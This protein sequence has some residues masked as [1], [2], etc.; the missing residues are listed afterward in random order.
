MT[1]CYNEEGNVIAVYERVKAVFSGINQYSYEHVFVDNASTDKTVDILEKIAEKD[2]NVKIIVNTRNFGPAHSSY[3]G[4]L[5]SKADATILLVA[6]LQDPP[7]LIKDSLASWEQG[8]KIVAGVKINSKESRIMFFLRKLY[9]HFITKISEVSLIKNFF[10]FGLYDREVI[11][12]LKALNEPEPYLRGLISSI[13]Y[14]IKEIGYTQEKRE[15]GFSKHSFYVLYDIAMSGITSHSKL[16]LRIATLLGFSCSFLSF[17]VAVIFFIVKL[18]WWSQFSLGLA[19]LIIGLFALGSVQLFCIGIL[20][21]YIA[22]INSR[23]MNRPLVIE[24]ERIN[25]DENSIFN[26]TIQKN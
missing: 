23:V 4:L 24:K 16:P 22:L 17:I 15:R 12:I 6:D 11:N 9:Y 25:F 2:K 20:G 13:G 1:P 19:P 3:H 21:E 7:E 8:W 18:I 5:Q 10:G 14:P 26:T